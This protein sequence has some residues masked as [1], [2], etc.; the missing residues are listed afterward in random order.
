MG[1]I[2]PSVAPVRIPGYPG[3]MNGGETQEAL[4]VPMRGT[5]DDTR[6]E[7]PPGSD[8]ASNGCLPSH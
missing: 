4:Q 7:R 2:T 6:N 8:A 3:Y 5:L 1:E